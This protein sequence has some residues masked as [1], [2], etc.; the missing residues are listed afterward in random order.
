MTNQSFDNF[1][2]QNFLIQQFFFALQFIL[3]LIQIPT[4]QFRL[5]N[6][7]FSVVVKSSKQ[8]KYITILQVLKKFLNFNY[9]STFIFFTNMQYKQIRQ[10]FIIFKRHFQIGLSFSFYCRH[11][12]IT[13]INFCI[14]VLVC[15]KTSK[16]H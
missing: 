6:A 2:N 3:Y 15:K 5:T 10:M 9:T 14:F 16:L 4:D 1:F 7:S 11:T 13:T 8:K 12:L